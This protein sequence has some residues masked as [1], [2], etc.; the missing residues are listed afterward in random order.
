MTQATKT[1][2]I[3]F[4][5]SVLLVLLRVTFKST[6][7]SE[8]LSGSVLSFDKAKVNRLEVRTPSN[9]LITLQ[10]TMSGWS[11]QK[12]G[13]ENS[14]PAD[15]NA[16]NTALE[17]IAELKPKALLTRNESDFSR[18]QVDSTGTEVRLFDGS[19]ELAG[20]VLGRFQFVS[21][22]EF[23]TYVR[24]VN[25]NEVVAVNGFIS[26]N[27]NKNVDGWRDK[28]VWNTDSKSITQIDFSFPGDSSFTMRKVAENAWVSGLD[29]LSISRVNQA[30]NNL[31]TLKA[32]GFSYDETPETFGTSNLRFVAHLD[33][34]IKQELWLKPSGETEFLA[35][36]SGFD[37]VFKLNKS[38]LNNSLLHGKSYFKK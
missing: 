32:N 8:A 28:N 12:E 33:N 17:Q 10:K 15:E 34:G 5:V 2:G 21:Q 6:G 4:A 20:L 31:A 30:V 1:L 26:S 23:N 25:K 14:Y 36:A 29:T 27:F 13:E 19:K 9:G 16:I 35:K 22:Q 11:V 37:Y 18:Y 7:N 38:S 3:L 24:A